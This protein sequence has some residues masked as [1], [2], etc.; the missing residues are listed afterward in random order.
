TA[1]TT[2]DQ[3][4]NE[5]SGTI[6]NAILGLAGRIG[7]GVDFNG[8]GYIDAGAA[9]N[10][11]GITETLTIMTWVRPDQETSDAQLLVGSGL[12]NS[13]NGFGFGI[14]GTTLWFSDGTTTVS[15]GDI[16]LVLNTWQ[17]VAVKVGSDG[18]VTFYLDGDQ[19]GA[20][21][22]VSL[23]ANSDDNLYL[24]GRPQANGT[25]GEQFYGQMD[26]LFIYA[27]SL[28]ASEIAAAY[29]NQFRWFRKQF[30]TNLIVD[31]DVPTITLQ[32][33]QTHWPNSY[34]QL[35]VGTTDAT[36]A[37]WS[38]EMGLQA[39][40]DGTMTWQAAPACGDVSFGTV[41]CP[42]F[43]PSALDGEG[44]YQLQFRAVDTV[45]N[46]TTSQVYTLYV[47]ETAP[48]VSSDNDGSFW[49]TLTPIVD[50]ELGWLLPLSGSVTDLGGMG[51]SGVYTPSVMVQLMSRAG[52][53]IGDAQ[54]V[55]F[56]NATDWI[57]DYELFGRFHGRFSVAITA[58]DNV[59][60]TTTTTFSSEPL[61]EGS[62]KIDIRPP[63]VSADEWLLPAEIINQPLTIS[64]S[65]SELPAWGEAIGRYHFE[66]TSGTT[67][68][69]DSTLGNHAECTNCPTGTAALFGQALQF[70]G[71][72]DTV[73]T[74]FL[75]NP[76]STTFSVVLWFNAASASAGQG[77]RALLQQG[78]VN[79][80]GR[81]LLY[82]DANNRVRSNLGIGTTGTFAAPDAI[83]HDTWHHATLTYDGTEAQIFLNGRLVRTHTAIAENTQG[84]LFIGS[85]FG[86]SGFYTGLID[87][88]MVFERVLSANEVEALAT[89]DVTGAADVEIWLEPFSFDGSL[90]TPDWQPATVNDPLS[91]L[92]TWAYTLPTGLEDFYQINVRGAD[93]LSNISSQ[94]T[95]WRGIIDMVAPT[96]SVSA[97]H[98]GGGSAAQTEI[99]F[100][101]AD[102][103]L[104]MDNVDAPCDELTWQTTSYQADTMRIDGV[105]ATCRVA[106]HV[107]D[108][109]TISACDLGGQCSADLVTLSASPQVS[110][111][112]IITPTLN[113]HLASSSVTVPIA[114][115]AYDPNGIK[116][117]A[118]QI[119][120][121]DYE[122]VTFNDEP[123]DTTWTMTDWQPLQ[124]GTYTLTAVMTNTLNVT[125][126]DTITVYVDIQSCQT[127]YTGDD[128]TDFASADAS[129]LQLA[130]D[131]APSGSTIKV[132]G[133]CA[134]VQGNGVMTQTVEITK[135]L[136][137]IGGYAQ[138]S[139]WSSSQ[140]N[141][142]E[143]QLDAQG[144]GR[145]VT[146]LDAGEVTLQNLTLAQGYAVAP[147]GS[148]NP[149]NFGGGLFVDDGDSVHLENVTIRDSFAE[150][151]GSGV[152]LGYDSTLTV[153]GSEIISNTIPNIE[154]RRGGGIF[155]RNNATLTMTHS[156][157]AYNESQGGGG[158]YASNNA[159]VYVA[160]SAI[161]DN[162]SLGHGGG[163]FV[164]G[165][166]TVVNS[167]ISG[168]VGTLGGALRLTTNA[169][170]DFSFTTI[171]SNTG[172]SGLEFDGAATLSNTIIAYHTVDCNGTPPVDNGYNLASDSSCGFAAGTSQ[173][174]TDPLLSPLGQHGGTTATHLPSLIS[175]ALQA[176][177]VGV[178]GCGT[179][180]TNDQRGV[181]RPKD[182][183]C[184]IGSVEGDPNQ[185]PVAMS[186]EYAAV[187]DV[188]LTV[189]APGVLANDSDADG[190][191]LTTVLAADVLNGTLEL[192]SS[193]AFTYTGTANFCGTDRFR[194]YVND[195]YANSETVAVTLTIAC[196]NDDPITLPNSY[197]I[198]EDTPD[199]V[200]D[201]LANDSDID[202]NDLTISGVG[203]LSAGGSAVNK[204]TEIHYTPAPNFFGMET[205]TYTVADGFGGEA[206]AAVTVTVTAVNDNP[207]AVN[208]GAETDEET[209]VEIYV[210]ANDSDIEGDSLSISAIAQGNNGSVVNNGDHLVYTPDNGFQGTDTFTYTISDGH[211]GSDTAFVTVLVAVVNTAPTAE[212]GGPYTVAQG[213][214]IML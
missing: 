99:T 111:V 214:T 204:G 25:I 51:A 23:V 96:V 176:I 75:F 10:I 102:R 13:A 14:Q 21:G 12:D 55:T 158:I 38:F 173:T 71:V 119:N 122:Q 82:L 70:D 107:L 186:D 33:T 105:S 109:I 212:A 60:N 178:N 36:S 138:D 69:D 130:V 151:Y 114:G 4:P 174:S 168:N 47:D 19:A 143:T 16:G 177:P 5:Y 159:N 192:A 77:S 59:G 132:A 179:A 199:S 26:E 166:L 170:A 48:A 208:D 129:A 184:D 161:H 103:F 54:Q 124:S 66:E 112:A 63:S 45:G 90:N 142:Y 139:D 67:F 110:S 95:V 35:A 15:S 93:D 101:A 52:R 8:D 207:V 155:M 211:G 104:D 148:S 2:A 42:Y 53:P 144:N 213:A 58:S 180:V 137:L 206:M 152:Y 117:I 7:N 83:A 88:V 169:S 80:P 91:N 92:S 24:G 98:I 195:G 76:I 115:Q 49:S 62:L 209:A 172:T 157:V 194:Y 149:A 72:D 191:D 189:V 150:W 22:V 50:T 156:T 108:P 193:G 140:P 11:N 85:S 41:W 73:T 121:V 183:A 185:V 43:D 68:Y 128:V 131:A 29:D 57:L 94:R 182:N 106:G 181:V 160:H 201:V 39:P 205:F 164:S 97:Q 44:V 30:D 28:P 18:T 154:V 165:N 118:L 190:Y 127:E 188:T 100:T 78:S 120:D 87:E 17:Q 40:S 123:I 6:A 116:A 20:N 46:E 200:F 210:L 89:S 31:N 141:L 3:S 133:L 203:L 32:T 163:L 56:T 74:P 37:I 135:S 187:E 134:G 9:T 136:T 34:I 125:V 65:A 126:T 27:R 86:S 171:V 79:G 162:E 84:G 198:A 145:V 153:A 197:T 64:G 167:T 147:N 1:T 81:T 175:P 146:I 202:G 113:A 61:S 196:T